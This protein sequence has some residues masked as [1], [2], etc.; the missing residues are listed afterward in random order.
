MK[1][2][3]ISANRLTEPYPVYPL[4]LDYVAGAIPNHH[5]VQILDIN[6]IQQNEDIAE[7]IESFSPDIIGV[8]MR[9]IDNTDTLTPKGFIDDYKALVQLIKQISNASIVLGG[10]GFSLFPQQLLDYVDADYGIVGEGERFSLLLD[11]IE[12]K[13]DSTSIPCVV[14]RNTSEC[15]VLPWKQNIQRCFQANTDHVEFYRKHG[16]MFNLQTKRGCPFHCIYCTYPLIEG[17]E[18]RRSDSEQVAEMALTLQNA[19]AKY[20]FVSDSVFNSDCSHNL[21]IAKAFQK[22]GISIPWGAFFSPIRPTK[23]Y[24]TILADSGLTH[25]EF[26]TESLSTTMLSA[27]HKPFTQDHIFMA[28]EA[29]IQAGL[30]VAHYFLLGGPSESVETLDETLTLIEQLTKSVFFFFCGVRIY[31]NTQLHRMAVSEGQISE[32]TDLLAPVFYYSKSIRMDEIISKV[33]ERS[34]QRKN[35]V[36]GSG[37]NETAL[38]LA[39]LYRRGYTGPLWEYLIV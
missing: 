26:G 21:E 31:P 36:I 9:N 5:S 20:L 13:K 14:T 2:L 8:S 25:V 33:Q 38:L 16:G 32:S 29:A 15:Q 17:S 37:G 35:W 4:G 27:Y 7:Y 3:L 12:H 1:I 34:L 18:L 19:G 6:I 24:Y 11:A 10:S 39:K 23:E 28:H 22:K 30:K